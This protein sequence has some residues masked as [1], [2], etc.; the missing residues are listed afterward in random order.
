M[1]AVEGPCT[2]EITEWGRCV[3]C[4]E[5]GGIYTVRAASEMTG[6]Q[7]R[8]WY[9]DGSEEAEAFSQKRPVRPCPHG[10]ATGMVPTEVS[11]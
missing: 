10:L 3:A 2:H 7:N 1:S 8:G 6:C 5:E 4:G 9:H 11:S